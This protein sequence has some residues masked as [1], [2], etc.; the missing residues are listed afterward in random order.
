MIIFRQA[1]PSLRDILP[2]ESGNQTGIPPHTTEKT[3]RNPGLFY[4]SQ[5]ALNPGFQIGILN[6]SDTLK[7]FSPFPYHKMVYILCFT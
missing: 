5:Y 7:T 1:V 4:R 3:W 6:R 2:D